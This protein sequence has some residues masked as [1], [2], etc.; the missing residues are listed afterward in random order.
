MSTE[1]QAYQRLKAL[2]PSAFWQRVENSVGTG[3]PDVFYR[4]QLLGL[5]GQSTDAWIENKVGHVRSDGTVICRKMRPSQHAWLTGYTGRGGRGMIAVYAG[6]AL[7]VGNFTHQVWTGLRDGELT[8]DEWLTY[9]LIKGGH[10]R[11]D[12]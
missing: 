10:V 6:G 2:E 7:G 4:G 11:E 5:G 12:S 1:K 9:C 3:F 8:W